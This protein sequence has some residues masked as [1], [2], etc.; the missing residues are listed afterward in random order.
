M[1]VELPSSLV[2]RM[3][4]L[5]C[6]TEKRKLRGDHVGLALRAAGFVELYLGGQLVDDDGKART[7]R[8]KTTDPLL[9]DLLAEVGSGPQR[10]WN[11]WIARGTGRFRTAVRNRLADTGVI[12]VEPYRILGIFPAHRIIV[13][14]SRAVTGLRDL[15]V[16]TLRDGVPA[17]RVPPLDAATTAIAAQCKMRHVISREQARDRKQRI[18]QLSEVAGPVISG[19]GRAVRDDEAAAASYGAG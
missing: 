18:K 19:L 1:T 5:S 4:L 13:R 16:R 2:S 3:F 9:D 15:V 10:R 12:R 17:N 7:T 11:T 14:D 8:K 6:D